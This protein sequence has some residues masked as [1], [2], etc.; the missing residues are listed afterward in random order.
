M[1]SKNKKAPV[2]T[3]GEHFC[4]PTI[5]FFLK[6]DLPILVVA[7]FLK[8]FMAAVFFIRNLP[9]IP[10]NGVTVICVTLRYYCLSQG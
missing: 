1:A 8:Q 3:K 9:N 2:S 7:T 10:C 6:P 4:F 5:F